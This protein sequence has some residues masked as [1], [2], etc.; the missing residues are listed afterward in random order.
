MMTKKELETLLK[1]FGK[2]LKDCMYDYSE[3]WTKNMNTESCP[4]CGEEIEVT[5]D[6]RT[7]CPEC[8]RKEVLPCAEC[9]LS[10]LS[11]C[12]WNEDTICSAFPK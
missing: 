7:P 4:K 8:G 1:P 3:F 9:P 10:D 2:T 12:D 5:Q 6:G 11:L